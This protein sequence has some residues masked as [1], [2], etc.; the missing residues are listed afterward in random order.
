MSVDETIRQ[1]L[2]QELRAIIR[3]EVAP[4]LNAHSAPGTTESAYFNVKQ[5]AEQCRV[6]VKTVRS[7]I[8]SGR[9][10]SNRAGARNYLVARTDMERFLSRPDDN[11]APAV[12]AQ[13]V[14]ILSK[15]RGGRSDG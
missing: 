15:V 2:R 5:V 14:S 12:D 3:E 1:L 11:G 7:W 4:L 6:S 9:L 8:Q 13:V 10:K